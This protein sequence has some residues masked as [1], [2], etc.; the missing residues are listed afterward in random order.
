VKIG[1]DV[2]GGIAINSGEIVSLGKLGGVTIGGSLVGGSNNF[3]GLITST[4]DI[5][6][7]AIGGDIIGSNAGP[8]S[9]ANTGAIFA[10]RIGT[11]VVGG[12][13]VAGI[14]NNLLTS[15]TNSATIRAVHDIGSL[16][17]KGSLIGSVATNPLDVIISAG[18]QV[19]TSTTKDLA[20]GKIAI[21]GRVERAEILAGYQALGLVPIDGDAQIGPVTVGGDWIASDLVA[22]VKDGGAPGFG[23]AGDTSGPGAT[24]IA[25]IASIVI[26]GQIQGTT[27]AGDQFGFESHKIGS[28]KA[29]GISF[30][31]VSPVP[32]SPLTG[33]DV[34]AREI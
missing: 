34:T 15:V 10:N 16:T 14:D 24:G 7:V 26:G 25:K 33:G 20:I 22:G 8:I 9:I 4:G 12:S 19:A 5:G 27:A 18:G 11:V 29:G 28:L 32:L 17:V 13:I 6:S 3:T 23:D 30:S 1:G 21:G 31:V 2:I